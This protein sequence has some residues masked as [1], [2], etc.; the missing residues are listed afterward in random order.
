LMNAVLRR[1]PTRLFSKISDQHRLA[2][3]ADR[4]C[5]SGGSVPGAWLAK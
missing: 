1:S 4:I 3:G 5:F 2:S